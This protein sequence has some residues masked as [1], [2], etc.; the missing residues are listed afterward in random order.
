MIGH[1]DPEITASYRWFDRRS[2]VYVRKDGSHRIVLAG[3]DKSNL[4]EDCFARDGY[5]CV[6]RGDLLMCRGRLELSHTPPM[7]D[8]E[9]S[10]E[11]DKV[12][13]RCDRH[14]KV[15]DN[16]WIGKP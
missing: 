15:Y 5:Q 11:L 4:R 8:P 14:H 13:A 9:G 16:R 2:K 12:K 7:S 10:D 1:L 3:R 6:D